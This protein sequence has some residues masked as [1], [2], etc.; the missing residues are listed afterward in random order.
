MS[1][2]LRRILFASLLVLLC[3]PAFSQKKEKQDSLV[4]LMSAKSVRL[5]QIDGV[6]YR[7]AIEANFLHNDT[8]LICD[9]ALWNVSTNVIDATGNVKV[10]QEETQLT[11]DKLTYRVDDN[12][13]EFRGSLVQLQD[14]DKNTL[15][16]RNLDYNTKD[17]VAVF[18]HGAS[19]R[20][21][22]G[23]IIESRDGTY[24][25]AIKTFIFENS[26]NM[27]T[28]SVF[29]KTGRLEYQADSSLAT[30]SGGLD[31][32]KGRDMLSSKHGWYNKE[33]EHFLFR[34]DVH[35]LSPTQEIW[36]DSLYY[37]R[38]LEDVKMIGNVQVTD[39]TREVSA[40][41]E[42]MFYQDSLSRITME[43]DAAVAAA[44][45]NQGQKDTIYVSAD[46]IVYKD[47]QKNLIPESVIADSQNRTK[48]L[49]VD[50]VSEYRRKAAEASAK[51]AEEKNKGNGGPQ[52]KGG[53]VE[54]GTVS[55]S[56]SEPDVSSPP[57]KVM[58]VSDSLSVSLDSLALE[59]VL[60]PQ[61]DTSKIGFLSAKGKVK[62]FRSD[63]Q[64]VC[65]SLEY[66]D[67]DS[68]ARLYIDPIVWNES[69]RQYRA[70]SLTIIIKDKKM[71]RASLMSNAFIVIQ[72]DS[73]CFDQIKS[74]EI[75]AYFDDETALR[76]FD[77]LGGA[78][79]LFYLQ[80]NDAFATV[81]KVE[82][83][84]LSAK[85]SEGEIDTIYYYDS[86][87]NDAYPV[88][89]FPK[90]EREMKGFS[91]LPELR[92]QSKAD[93]TSHVLRPSQRTAYEAK[94]RP[95]FNYTN[96]YFPG[97]VKH[98]YAEL[99][100]V[101]SLRAARRN[102]VPEESVDSTSVSDSLALALP[103]MSDSLVVVGDSL[104]VAADSLGVQL[105]SLSAVADSLG[106]V[107]D[108]LAVEAPFD[109]RA[110]KRAEAERKRQERI[111]KREERW[112]E[113]DARDALKAA[114]DKAQA[115]EKR[116]KATYKALLRLEKRAVKEQKQLDRYVERYR[117]KALKKKS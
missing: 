80:E 22:D 28:D 40:M 75:M 41:A 70:D 5:L 72:E 88:V 37:W 1:Q 33:K 87:Q 3:V 27:Y 55:S 71:D 52:L 77:A 91:W 81:N 26:V 114:R 29:I 12:L 16:T 35:G 50:P 99:A 104:A 116:R 46:R 58:P 107:S 90:D 66:S 67:L 17:S 6:S 38:A 86:P 15:R 56:T 10:L 19:M 47:I 100:R 24:E 39:S 59:P 48:E 113:L 103:G 73:I 83:K 98:I 4:R 97:H 14:K 8:Y 61:I 11:S 94:R 60:E 68:L 53:A 85:F 54:S 102:A 30:F 42:I 95:S 62:V 25:S 7:E 111:D 21:K 44:S 82:S 57:D 31:A 51:A 93:V 112:A 23:Q 49:N 69:N 2:L 36:C 101:D 79:A 96:Q 115:D 45:D 106:V 18:S 76:R 64:A 110:V 89:Q 9:T 109:P 117:K 74:A 43:R 84:M 20:D 34:D 65:D 13:A 63:M 32:W 92:P 78:N 108:S 105:D